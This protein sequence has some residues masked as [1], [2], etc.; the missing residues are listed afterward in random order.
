MFRFLC[1]RK[2]KLNSPGLALWGAMDPTQEGSPGELLH[3]CS[4]R[5]PDATAADGGGG[6][7][8]Q[9]RTDNKTSSQ[10][11]RELLGLSLLEYSSDDDDSD[12]DKPSSTHAPSLQAKEEK[13]R[14]SVD[15]SEDGE[16]GNAVLRWA[17]R[18]QEGLG[19]GRQGE[20]KREDT[21]SEVTVGKIEIDDDDMPFIRKRRIQVKQTNG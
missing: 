3:L 17:Q 6:V 11:M 1:I 10:Q 4:G 9:K 18:N 14:A 21:T 5:F 13:L 12:T 8:E 2:E 16:G 15:R 20:G 7:G 19:V